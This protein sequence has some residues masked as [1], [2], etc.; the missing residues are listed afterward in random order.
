MNKQ[1]TRSRRAAA[2][3]PPKKASAWWLWIVVGVLAIG[4][5]IGVAV[6][7]MGG[8]DDKVSEGTVGTDN[9]S[10]V[11]ETQPVTVVGEPLAQQASSG[12]DSSVNGQTPPTLQG[13]TFA[14]QPIDVTPGGTAKMVV[15]LAHWCPHCN[16]EIPVIQQWSAAGRVPEGLDIIGVSTAV[17]NQRDNY[18]PSQW[19]ERMKWTWPVLA[20][21]SSGD[22]SRAWGVGGFPTIVIVG[23]DGT[24][25]MR[26]SGEMSVDELDSFVRQALAS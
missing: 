6:W 17:T 2:A 1:A 10:S 19:I 24:V 11:A 4:A 12:P 13:F 8:G 26:S 23:T 3:P 18:P 9:S 21:S 22:A 16:R 25:K 5:L 14:G 15:F 20:D 7:S